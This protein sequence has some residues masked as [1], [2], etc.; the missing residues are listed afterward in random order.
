MNVAIFWKSQG[1]DLFQLS[2]SIS[3][4]GMICFYSSTV[5][6]FKITWR[7]TKRVKILN[8]YPSIYMCVC[9]RACVCVCT[10]TLNS[11]SLK[12]VDKFTYLGSSVSS[13]EKDIKTWLAK[14]WTAINGLL[15][16]W[17]SDLTDK[18]KRSFFQ[19][20]AVSILLYGC[21]TWT[22]TKRMEKKLD[23]NY[24]RMQRAILNKSGRQ[25]STKQQLYDHVPPI[26]I[27]IKVRRTRHVGHC[28]RS[29]NELIRD[30]LPW[31]RSHGRAKA[32]RPART[33]I[34]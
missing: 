20:A 26:M 23:G 28:W 12:L 19:A 31:T 21:T 34:Q 29:R 16:I 6:F 33:F 10:N 8:L 24:T 11:S 18:M 13:N 3:K 5:A 25:H 17:K 32:G 22:L 14:A 30:V 1:F 2:S 4:D 27:T 9:A 7:Q 15:V